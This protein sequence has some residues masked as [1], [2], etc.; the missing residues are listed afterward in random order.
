VNPRY[1]ASVEVL[2]LALGFAAFSSSSPRREQGAD[3]TLAYAAGSQSTIAKCVYFAPRGLRFPDSGPWDA[4]LTGPF[5][6]WRR[7]NFADIPNPGEAI[8]AGS[9]VL[10]F[11]ASAPS[12][13]TCR[14][15]LQIQAADLDRLFQS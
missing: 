4:D 14:R 8:E 6:P 13:E 12:V 7:P 9:P 3:P 11:F 15:S 1:P 5:D 2:E 10:T